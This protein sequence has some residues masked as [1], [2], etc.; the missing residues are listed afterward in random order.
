LVGL[1]AA[2]SFRTFT[3]ALLIYPPVAASGENGSGAAWRQ[4]FLVTEP[5]TW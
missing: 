3:Q 1:A 5:N 4:D 2:A